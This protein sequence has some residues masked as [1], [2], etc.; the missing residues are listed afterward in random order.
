MANRAA[1][2]VAA[3]GI[4][5]AAVGFVFL[6]APEYASIVNAPDAFVTLVG[7][8]ALLQGYRVVRLR[9]RN[10][11]AEFETPDPETRPTLPTPGD[12]LG[13]NLRA[14]GRHRTARRER[15]GDRL[16][17]AAIEGITY[18]E[19]CSV[20]AAHEAL[21]HGT[22]TDDPIAAA[23]FTDGVPRSVPVLTRIRHTLSLRARFD[24]QARHAAHA[25]ADLY[26]VDR[27]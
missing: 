27:E 26:G 18:A 25:I 12:D 15:I 21:E 8:L 17:T 9:R 10:E 16:E 1:S 5:F 11:V 2:V 23:F 14:R 6:F 13:R 22:W 4:V 24:R 7:V 3:I 19:D 20:E